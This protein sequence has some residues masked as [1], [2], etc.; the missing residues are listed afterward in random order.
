[1]LK[2]GAFTLSLLAASAMAAVSDSDAAK[3]GASLTPIGAEKAGNA[4][5]T[6]PEWTGGLPENAAPVTDNGFVTDPFPNDKPK[7]VITAEN[8]DQYKDNLSP[9]QIAMFKRYPDTYRMPVFETR[10]S[11]AMPQSIYDAAKRNATHTNLVRGGNGLENFDTAVAFPMP[12]D[13]LEVIWNHIT[14]YRG[15]SARRVVAQAT[16]QVNGNYSLVKFVDEVIYANTL[17]DYSPEKHGNVLFYF[18]QQVTEPSRLAG[19][20]LLVHETLDQVK[21]PRMAWIYNAGQRRVRRAPQVAYDGPGTAAD[22]LRTSDN[23]D[24]FNGAPDRYDWK[25][26]GKKELYIP[27]NSYRLDSP[28]L[29]YSDIVK[30]GH[31]NQDLTRYEL[32]RV[33]EVEATLK[34]GERHIYAKRH[35]FIDE[36]TWQAAIV[37]HYDGRGQL[38]RVAEAHALYFYNVQVPLYAMET[39]YDLIS[40]RYLVMGMKNEE[41]NPYTYNYKAHSNQYTPAALRNA[42]VR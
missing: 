31:I 3:L 32:H 36:D 23:L 2:T 6:I 34:S 12:Q 15:G 33:W 35:F 40:G 30:A 24:L 14:R 26:V 8:V 20:V 42:G 41:R 17:T 38:W 5:G 1:M 21:E 19:N 29:K 16:P 11:A 25:L 7:F 13:G 37:D 39:L 4:A 10:R 28:E 9:G 27:Y 22:G 18:K